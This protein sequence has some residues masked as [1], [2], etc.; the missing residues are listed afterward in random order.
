MLLG[1][2][3][4][5]SHLGSFHFY[6]N[7]RRGVS[8]QIGGCLWFLFLSARHP[9]LGSQTP[10][11][12]ALERDDWEISKSSLSLNFVCLAPLYLKSSII[13]R[14]LLVSKERQIQVFIS[15]CCYVRN[16]GYF[17]LENFHE[18]V[19]CPLLFDK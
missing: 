12:V 14:T 5:R 11:N 15:R 4:L 17:L 13:P 19:F 1:I 9:G 16:Y 8:I 6:S 18:D 3:L 2:L 10:G 7:V